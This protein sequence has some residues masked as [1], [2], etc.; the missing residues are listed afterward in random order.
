[1]DV[2]PS[3]QHLNDALKAFVDMRDFAGATIVL[4]L[5]A[6]LSVEPCSR[7]HAVVVHGVL[8]AADFGEAFG[9]PSARSWLNSERIAS[10][11]QRISN[12]NELAGY[13]LF[14]QASPDVDVQVMEIQ[15]TEGPDSSYTITHRKAEKESPAFWNGRLKP[16]TEEELRE[17]RRYE[18]G[19]TG[20]L[21]SLL[22]QA[23]ASDCS[24]RSWASELREA[25]QDTVPPALQRAV[26]LSG[27]STRSTDMPDS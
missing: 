21:A 14:G 3:T 24:A 8:R 23:G 25:L 1:V 22:E 4:Q 20:Y 11:L 27:I 2:Q 13:T 26:S 9:T 16:R 6:P 15:A 10:L 7:T 12:L 18:Y 17:V 19:S 5:Y